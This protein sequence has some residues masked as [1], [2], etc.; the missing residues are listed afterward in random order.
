MIKSTDEFFKFMN[1]TMMNRHKPDLHSFAAQT[2]KGVVFV[3]TREDH[4]FLVSG[5]NINYC[6]NPIQTTNYLEKIGI[7]Y[8]SIDM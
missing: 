1:K 4:T 6:G 5:E 3:E 7:N 2:E 8:L